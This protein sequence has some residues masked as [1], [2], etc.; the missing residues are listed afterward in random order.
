MT[1]TNRVGLHVAVPPGLWRLLLVAAAY[2]VISAALALA[3]A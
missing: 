3:H 2:L 1:I